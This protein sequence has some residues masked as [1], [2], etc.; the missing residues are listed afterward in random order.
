MDELELVL[1]T[2]ARVTVRIDRFIARRQRPLPGFEVVRLP[3]LTWAV[4]DQFQYSSILISI[5]TIIRVAA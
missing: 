4:G 1:N 3:R 5:G 2:A